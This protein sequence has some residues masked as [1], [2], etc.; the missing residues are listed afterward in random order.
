MSKKVNVKQI[1]IRLG[2][3]ILI[4][5][6]IL[7]GAY[8]LFRHFGIT[9][10]SK[11]QL[12]E[13]IA[14]FGVWGALIFIFVSF[15]QVTFVPIPGAVTILAGNL[16]FGPWLSLLYSFIGMF[17]GAV[18]AFYLG[19]IFGRPFV[20]WVVGDKETVES[21][22]KRIKNKE[23]VVF[24]FM[25]LLPL[26]PDDALCAVAGITK[27]RWRDFILMQVITRPTS[28]LGTL[29]FMSGEIIPYHGWGLIVL[30]AVCVL[31]IIAF[32]IS[33]KNAD[34]INAWLDRFF[35][36]VASIKRKKTN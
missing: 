29:F 34:K 28:I 17:L 19:R 31:S 5:A 18:L 4:I 25:F 26:F 32:I 9:D 23:F 11:E 10:I 33:Y 27:L 30:G 13:K 21:Y 16:L 22:L 7:V 14:Q 20:N 8:F 36:K 35:E 15:L 24:F 1:L 12:R 3:S 6:A 2:I